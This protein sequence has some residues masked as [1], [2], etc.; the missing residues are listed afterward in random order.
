GQ[1]ANPIGR[2]S[3]GTR[4]LGRASTPADEPVDLT[5]LRPDVLPLGRHL[6]ELVHDP[7]TNHLT[8]VQVELAL[9][10][11]LPHLRHVVEQ[12]VDLLLS[13][14]ERH[15]ALSDDRSGG[16]LTGPRAAA[17]ENEEGSSG[18]EQRGRT[19]HD[20]DHRPY[21]R[22]H[23]GTFRKHEHAYHASSG[24]RPNKRCRW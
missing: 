24:A 12:P 9:L 7:P 8:R 23:P 18:G 13:P 11:R 20:P 2:D 17:G 6:G 10:L 19:A 22:T 14:G 1:I 21:L 16:D 15:R 5:L 3:R 4:D